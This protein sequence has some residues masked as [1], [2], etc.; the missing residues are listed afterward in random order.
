MSPAICGRCGWRGRGCT[1]ERCA[2]LTGA[3]VGDAEWAAY[4]AAAAVARGAEPGAPACVGCGVTLTAAE[5]QDAGRDECGPCV[6]WA[7]RASDACACGALETG[8][9]AAWDSGE[10]RCYAADQPTQPETIAEAAVVLRE[11]SEALSRTAPI[12]DAVPF[13]LQAETRRESAGELRA[14]APRLW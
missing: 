10:H 8:A 9:A 7:R 5:L 13:T 1:A 3:L 14:R 12:V 2:E 11:L 6:A 4:V